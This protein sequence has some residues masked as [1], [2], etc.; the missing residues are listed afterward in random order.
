MSTRAVWSA[1][2]DSCPMWIGQERTPK[3]AR[4]VAKRAGWVFSGSN[5]YCTIACAP[6]AL[7]ERLE[8]SLF[9]QACYGLSREQ[10]GEIA[11]A[12]DQT[13]DYR[14]L[15]KANILFSLRRRP[16]SHLQKVIEALRNAPR[17]TP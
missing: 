5:M 1:W 4:N 3:D 7:Q 9:L 13:N 2:C 12:T 16:P 15:S 17:S 10:I 11:S 6:Q 8:R 14:R